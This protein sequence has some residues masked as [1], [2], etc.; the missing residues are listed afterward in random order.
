MIRFRERMSLLEEDTYKR[1][2]AKILPLITWASA[3]AEFSDGKMPLHFAA[4]YSSSEAV[5]QALLAAYAKAVKTTTKG[6]HTP[7]HFAAQYSSSVAVVRAARGVPGGRQGD[8]QVRQ[9][10]GQQSRKTQYDRRGQSLLRER[11]ALGSEVGGTGDGGG[12][13]SKGKGAARGRRRSAC[14]SYRREPGHLRPCHSTSPATN[15]GD[16]TGNDPL[17]RELQPARAQTRRAVRTDY[18]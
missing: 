12:K 11:R 14:C 18:H 6:G 9:H 1:P 10:A 8:D 3:R 17:H 7:L 15:S 5:V 16:V 4:Q 13:G 2:D